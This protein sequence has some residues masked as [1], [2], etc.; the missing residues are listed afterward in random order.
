MQYQ[1]VQQMLLH[2]ISRVFLHFLVKVKQKRKFIEKNFQI[3]FSTLQYRAMRHCITLKHSTLYHIEHS[4]TL[5]SISCWKIPKL[6][7]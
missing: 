4:I 1:L 5:S 6:I 3:V 7:F 2:F